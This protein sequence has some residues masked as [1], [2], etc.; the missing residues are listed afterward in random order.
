MF[1][2]VGRLVA[3]SGRRGPGN[4]VAERV[5]HC[6]AEPDTRA[7]RRNGEDRGDLCSFD[8][9]GG[10]RHLADEVEAVIAA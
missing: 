7:L 4:Q 1:T 6:D 2:V 9:G 5:H 3:C 8:D 10:D